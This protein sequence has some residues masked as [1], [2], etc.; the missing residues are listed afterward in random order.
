MEQRRARRRPAYAPSARRGR[1]P[2]RR[3]PAADVLHDRIPGAAL[4]AAPGPS[5][6]GGVALG[7]A[8]AGLDLGHATIVCSRCIS[9]PLRGPPGLTTMR[10][11]TSTTSARPLTAATPS[12]RDPPG[13]QLRA[14]G[15]QR[16]PLAQIAAAIRRRCPPRSAR[17]PSTDPGSRTA[18]CTEKNRLSAAPAWRSSS[19]RHR[20]RGPR[21]SAPSTDRHRRRPRRR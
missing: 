2:A 14:D 15:G 12:R 7:A 3:P 20:R 18:T 1:R 8:V 9:Y 5:G 6:R 17:W 10:T 16:R 19:A 4:A 13:V 11:H 21:R